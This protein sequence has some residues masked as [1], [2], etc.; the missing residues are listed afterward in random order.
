[1]KIGAI[2]PQIEMGGDP[3]AL[4]RIGR[5]VDAFGYDYLLMSDHVVGATHENRNPPM[6]EAGNSDKTPYHDPFVAFGYLAG[7]TQRI[8]LTTGVIILPQRQ[9]ALVARQTTDIDLLSNGRLRLGVGVGWNKVEFDALGQDFASRGARLTEQIG[10]LRQL[11]SEPLVT[12]NGK[13]DQL[14]R[15]NIVPRPKRQIPIY[16]GGYTEVAYKRS[17][18]LADGHMFMLSVDAAL[19]GWKRLKQLLAEEGRSV[20]GFGSDYMIQDNFGQGLDIPKVVDWARRWQDVG[21]THVGVV[22]A[23]LGFTTAEQ[24]ID[25]FTE[26]CARLRASLS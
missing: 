23:G 14:D 7:I 17:A 8:E 4:D 16:C 15:G 24:H 3:V 6:P 11:W 19:E 18:R 9:T 13:F 10:Y 21:G 2:Y 1:M 5:S 26:A 22:T 25:Y 12:F 20:A